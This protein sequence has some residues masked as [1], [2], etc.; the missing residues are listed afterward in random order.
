LLRG[1]DLPDP[2]ENKNQDD[3][4]I[5]FVVNIIGRRLKVEYRK[6]LQRKIKKIVDS[7]NG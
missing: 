7:K 2:Y 5:I 1:H 3:K 4:E 6:A